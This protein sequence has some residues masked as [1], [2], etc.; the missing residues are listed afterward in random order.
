MGLKLYRLQHL[1]LLYF[2]DIVSLSC[3][4]SVLEDNSEILYPQPPWV[5]G[6]FQHDLSKL[7]L[8]IEGLGLWSLCRPYM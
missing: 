1:F 2:N 5:L 7:S 4:Q 3:G 8:R 6:I